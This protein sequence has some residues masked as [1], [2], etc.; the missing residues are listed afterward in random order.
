MHYRASQTLSLHPAILSGL[1]F[2]SSPPPVLL[3]KSAHLHALNLMARTV[4]WL[5]RNGGKSKFGPS[6]VFIVHFNNLISLSRAVRAL[7]MPV[8]AFSSACFRGATSGEKAGCVR[9]R[10]CSSFEGRAVGYIFSWKHFFVTCSF[11]FFFLPPDSHMH[12]GNSWR[13]PR[14]HRPFSRRDLKGD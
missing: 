5:I 10:M 14:C 9:A 2:R 3:N 7:I 11:F 8:S 13:P 12:G 1:P 6:C 4:T